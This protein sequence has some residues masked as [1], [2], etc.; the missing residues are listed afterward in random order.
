MYTLLWVIQLGYERSVDIVV[1]PFQ[2]V[3]FPNGDGMRL[4]FKSLVYYQDV[5]VVN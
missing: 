1:N 4:F 5:V 3:Y 2:K